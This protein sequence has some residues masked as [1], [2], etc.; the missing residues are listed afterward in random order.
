MRSVSVSRRGGKLDPSCHEVVEEDVDVDCDESSESTGV[1]S[2][3]PASLVA[4]APAAVPCRRAAPAGSRGTAAVTSLRG[5][6][7]KE[8]PG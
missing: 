4:Q 7:I 5:A 1:R 3:V 8:I 2:S 6:T